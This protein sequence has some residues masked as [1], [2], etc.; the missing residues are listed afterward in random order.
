MGVYLQHLGVCRL[1][2]HLTRCLWIKSWHLVKNCVASVRWG[3]VSGILY[4]AV[5]SSCGSAPGNVAG[6][7]RE[8]IKIPITSSTSPESNVLKVFDSG[9]QELLFYH[10]HPGHEIIVF[11]IQQATELY[12]IKLDREGPNGVSHVRGFTVLSPYNILVSGLGTK[13][14]NVDK[15]HQIVKVYD[16]SMGHDSGSESSPAELSSFNYCDV[17]EIENGLVIPQF[18]PDRNKDGV[19]LDG[20][21]KQGMSLFAFISHDG[22]TKESWKIYLP[23]NYFDGDGFLSRTDFSTAYVEGVLY[24]AFTNS[25]TIH[26]RDSNGKIGSILPDNYDKETKIRVKISDIFTTLTE[27]TYFNSLLYSPYR[28]RFYRMMRIGVR[29]Q[30][31]D[32]IPDQHL[33]RY[34]NRFSIFVYNRNF[35]L[36]DEL[37]F[38][39]TKYNYGQFFIASGGF[40]LSL[41]NPFNPDFDENY[42]QFERFD[43]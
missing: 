10:N 43:I 6:T 3:Y 16:Y 31:K 1:N 19:L 42:L 8:I 13:L 32:G 35:Q 38:K 21:E 15:D 25:P 11:D 29:G 17:Y 37:H 40:Y 33:L 34:P 12:S 23:P 39:G 27:N 28:K 5:A 18:P 22:R 4:L 14:Y 30:E 9:T 7:Q 2:Y 41:D 20:S 26:F 24:W 36:I